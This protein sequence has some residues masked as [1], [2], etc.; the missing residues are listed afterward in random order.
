M[1]TKR[2]KCK[3]CGYIYEGERPPEHCPMCNAPASEFV[4][5][6]ENGNPIESKK[7]GI[8]TNGN[9][10]TIIYSCV[11]VI[12][13]A[14]LL[15]FVSSALKEPSDA[16]VRID[17]K[18]QILAALNIRGVDKSQVEAKYKEVVVAD[19]IINVNNGVVKPGTNK[20]QDGFKVANKEISDTNLP[21]Y[22]CKVNGETKYVLQL[23]GKGLWGA[24]W[25]FIALN[26]DKNTVCG[27]FFT[28]ES[29]TA[30]LGARIVEYEGFQKQF[31][32]KK[33][34]AAGSDN[35]LLSVVKMGKKDAIDGV[36]PAADS[37]CDAVTGATLTSNGVNNMLHDCLKKYTKFLTAK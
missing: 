23:T 10:Y 34:M 4:E 16:N 9:A 6:D 29:E 31:E 32:G 15:A 37:K 18:S 12:I 7:K 17:K 21:V 3:V 25:G 1:A 36:A 11:V 8:N 20:D 19:E 14:F 13:V 33:V 28:H 30:G 35:I 22:V 26:S 2:Y 24:I 5:I 27:A